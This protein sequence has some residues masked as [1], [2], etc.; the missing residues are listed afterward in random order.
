MLQK[1]LNE[2]FGQSN[3]WRWDKNA[4][5]ALTAFLCQPIQHPSAIWG[6]CCSLHW[7]PMTIRIK[8]N[9]L[10]NAKVLTWFDSSANS[11]LPVWSQSLLTILQP[12]WPFFCPSEKLTYL[13]SQGLSPSKSP[14][15]EN[16][17]WLCNADSAFRSG[18]R[19]SIN[20]FKA[21]FLAI[22]NVDHSHY[23][24]V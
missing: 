15:L 3:I 12:D 20:L 21:N 5:I 18:L 1:N 19:Q 13:R 7:F 4:G 11:A 22:S 6:F 14:C 23:F 24:I 9:L 10:T 2:H 8:P 16:S 17:S